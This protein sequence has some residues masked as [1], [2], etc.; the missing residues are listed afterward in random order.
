[1]T[2]RFAPL[3]R[4]GVGLVGGVVTGTVVGHVLGLAAGLL[5]GWA[6]GAL[7]AVVWILLVVWPMDAASTRAHARREDPGRRLARLIAVAGSVASLG[8]VAAV[9]LQS[10]DTDRAG[11]FVLAGIAVVSVVAS[12]ALIQTDYMLRMAHVYYAD[13]EGGIDFNQDEDPMFT[14][15]A[16]IA[17]GLGMTYQIS[18]T[19]L[20]TN[21]LR[22]IVIA[23]TLLAYV[24]GAV[25]LA[26]VVN[27]V[28]GLGG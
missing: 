1:M 24:F 5:S 19:D 16:Y 26:T 14:D 4:L 22:R 9:L 8:A 17:V 21:A 13:P 7:I 12:W 6:V 20:R 11:R 2:M 25:I 28:A 15:F 18:D 3:L 27:L 10:H 23:Q